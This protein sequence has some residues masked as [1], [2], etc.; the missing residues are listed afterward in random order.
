MKNYIIR[1]VVT[2]DHFCVLFDDNIILEM[3]IQN[4]IQLTSRIV[5]MNT[6]KYNIFIK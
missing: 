2:I 5:P 6:L 4:S 3:F 1:C